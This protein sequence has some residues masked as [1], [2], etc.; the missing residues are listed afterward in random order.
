MKYVKELQ[1]M[2]DDLSGC[3]ADAE[4]ADKGNS[5]AAVRYRETLRK[6]SAKAKDLR[7]KSLKAS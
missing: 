5:A 2:I 4:K 7:Q 3:M 6:L 1:S